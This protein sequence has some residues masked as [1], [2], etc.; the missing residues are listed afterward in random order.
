MVVVVMGVSG[1]GKTTVGR[2]LSARQGW[3]FYDA[4]DFHPAANV[5]KMS[6][7]VALTDVDRL[8]WLEKLREVI[9]EILS[10]GGSAVVACSALKTS[11]R[12]LLSVSNE[13]V[14]FVYLKGSYEAIERRMALRADHYMKAGMLAG[15]FAA[16]EEPKDAVVVD[17]ALEP[18]QIVDRVVEELSL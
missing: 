12:T 13:T 1:S 14:R 4:D 9:A 11:Y 2:L 7:G 5:E 3:P 16:L 6:A 10:D 17:V 18:A 8:P 15:Q